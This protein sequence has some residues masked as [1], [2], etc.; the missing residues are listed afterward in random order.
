MLVVGYCYGI[1][2]ERRLCEEV[3]LNL[4]Y[5]WFRELGLEDA[6]PDHSSFSKNPHGRFRESDILRHVFETVVRSCMNAGLVGGDGFATDASVIEA[7][8][9]RYKGVAG[10]DPIDWA[11]PKRQTRAVRRSPWRPSI[12]NQTRDTSHSQVPLELGATCDGPP[13]LST[14]V[15]HQWPLKRPSRY[16]IDVVLNGNSLPNAFRGGVPCGPFAPTSM[17]PSNKHRHLQGAV[18]VAHIKSGKVSFSKKKLTSSPPR[19]N[20]RVFARRV[21]SFGRGL[22]VLA[23]GARRSSCHALPP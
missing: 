7:D 11:D 4:A 17:E 19:Q 10:T 5:R 12:P 21:R 3:S 8:A 20:R 9:S 1:R 2:S 6:V 13:K 15:F 18:L 14:C 23:P 16:G 22:Q